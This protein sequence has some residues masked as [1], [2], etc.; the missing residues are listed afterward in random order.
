MLIFFSFIFYSC[1]KDKNDGSSKGKVEFAF[2]NTFV[3]SA[4]KTSLKAATD[5]PISYIVS[6]AIITIED[7][8][9]N[10]IQNAVSIPL[11]NMN[12]NYIS[13]PIAL[14][15][16]NYQLTEFLLVNQNNQV[17]YA[18][19]L[20]SSK[21]AYLV[22]QPLPIT[23]NIQ[24]N[25]V[26]NVK[27]EVLNTYGYSPE[28]FG[29]A[30]F[31]FN[32]DSTFNFLVGAFIYNSSAKNYQ[33]T[34][35]SI[36]IYYDSTLVYTGKLSNTLKDSSGI[37]SPSDSLGLTTQ[38]TLPAKY[39]SYK[40]V[41]TKPNYTTYQQTFT[42]A[43]LEQY[44]LSTNKGPLIVILTNSN[45]TLL[46]GLVAYYPFNGDV[47]DH[48]GN[49]NNGI[50]YG[51][52]MATADHHGNPNSAYYFNGINSYIQVPNSPSLNPTNQLTISL[53][54]E[55]DTFMNRYTS[56]IDKG[57]PTTS[58]FTNREY[59]E[60]FNNQNVIWIESSGDNSPHNYVGSYFPGLNT[61]FQFTAVIDR[62]VSHQMQVYINGVLKGTIPDSY[63][64]FTTNSYPLLIGS[65]SETNPEY[66]PFFKGRMDEIRIYNR[67][68]SQA[69]ITSLYNQ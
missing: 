36:A 54:I 39:S 67:V 47:L 27:P 24:T 17:I 64:Q 40:I 69:E 58:G 21:L 20:K 2:S 57:G 61:W 33:L 15:T 48:S 32:I 46:N 65:W 37:V 53:W 66:S 38:I 35:A 31:S 56:F 19:P 55:I 62:L 14:V 16:G 63:S 25:I 9:G 43:Q 34:T 59:F 51:N 12:G 11:T 42:K 4:L 41:I 7:A 3:T 10:I 52:L 60:Y 30:T 13:S 5:T 6:S 50:A 26:T 68:L 22:S 45:N 44:Y 28:D 29:Y 49:N 8:S 1:N 23:F 18:S